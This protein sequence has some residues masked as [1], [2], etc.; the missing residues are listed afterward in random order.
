MC[1]C[2]SFFYVCGQKSKIMFYEAWLGGG[3]YRGCVQGPD[4]GMRRHSSIIN[5]G[6][7]A[8][9]EIYALRNYREKAVCCTP[10]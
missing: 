10:L 6:R 9:T 5:L 2:V 3:A 7:L 4:A 8:R 1:V